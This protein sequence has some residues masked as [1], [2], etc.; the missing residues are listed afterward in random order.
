MN[1]LSWDTFFS[2]PFYNTTRGSEG[3]IFINYNC[4][5]LRKNTFSQRVAT[6]WNSLTSNIKSTNN[7]NT[8]KSLLDEH[9]NEL[10]ALYD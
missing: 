7:L 2:R 1:N 4:T 8:F 9:Y 5:N 6:Y 10:F 3:K